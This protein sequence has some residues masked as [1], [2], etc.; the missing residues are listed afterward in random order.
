MHTYKFQP[1]QVSPFEIHT[2]KLIY[3]LVEAQHT[4]GEYSNSFRNAQQMATVARGRD[5]P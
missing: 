3:L 2:T 4:H 5:S 1:A